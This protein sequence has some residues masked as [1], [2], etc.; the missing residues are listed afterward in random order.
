MQLYQL[1][2]DEELKVMQRYSISYEQLAII[3]L[4]FFIK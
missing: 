4:I 2:F 1:T 3:K